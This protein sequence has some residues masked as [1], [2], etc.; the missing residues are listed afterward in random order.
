MASSNII[1]LGCFNNALAIATLC[2]SPPDSFKPLSPTTVWIP[3]GKD[4]IKLSKLASW[5][6]FFSH[7]PYVD[8]TVFQIVF[9]G[10][11][12]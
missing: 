6:T 4:E 12:K 3:K 1:I 5:I 8:I 9:K 2:F 7:L 10:F 11:I